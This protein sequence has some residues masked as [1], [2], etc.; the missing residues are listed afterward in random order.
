MGISETFPDSLK[1]MSALNKCLAFTQMVNHE[2]LDESFKIERA[3]FSDGTTV[4]VNWETKNVEIKPE[5]KVK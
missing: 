3:T 1:R 4:T 5:L 2:F